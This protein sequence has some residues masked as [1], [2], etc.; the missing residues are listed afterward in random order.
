MEQI[1]KADERTRKAVTTEIVTEQ[2]VVVNEERAAELF[3]LTDIAPRHMFKELLE[4]WSENFPAT[5]AMWFDFCCEQIMFGAQRQLSVIRH[6]SLRTSRG[7]TDFTP[8]LSR[9]RRLPFAGCYAI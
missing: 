8:V 3:G 4:I 2:G 5:K 9:T 1:R 6:A 7:Q